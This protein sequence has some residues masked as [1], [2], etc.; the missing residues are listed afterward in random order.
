LPLY[1]TAAEE[2]GAEDSSHQ[3]RTFDLQDECASWFLLARQAV[4]DVM[5][6]DTNQL[7]CQAKLHHTTSTTTVSIGEWACYLKWTAMCVFHC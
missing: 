5:Y 4:V 3:Y 6:L 7:E 2:A 1:T